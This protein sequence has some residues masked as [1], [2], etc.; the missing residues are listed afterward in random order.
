MGE[1]GGRGGSHGNTVILR[2][3]K[4]Y[5]T[6]YAHLNNFNKKAKSG[7]KVRQ[8]QV[9]GYVGSTGRTTGPH[10]HYE[11]QVNGVHKNPLSV[12]VPHA[13][14]IAGK[15]RKEFMKLAALYKGKLTALLN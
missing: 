10:L 1:I 5:H 3:G 4:K 7:S 6:L 14:P 8:G 2:H 11:F 15:E 9:I 13:L 12:D